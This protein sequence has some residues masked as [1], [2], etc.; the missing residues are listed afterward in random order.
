MS[1]PPHNSPTDATAIQRRYCKA[2]PC[3]TSPPGEG[4]NTRV[5]ATM[6]RISCSSKPTC[7]SWRA[8]STIF[9]R[10]SSWISPRNEPPCV[11]LSKSSKAANIP[12]KWAVTTLEPAGPLPGSGASAFASICTST[13]LRG[14]S[15]PS[16]AGRLGHST[17]SAKKNAAAQSGTKV[18]QWLSSQP[19]GPAG[20]AVSLRVAVRTTSGGESRSFAAVSAPTPSSISAKAMSNFSA[21]PKPRAAPP[22]CLD[23]SGA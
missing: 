7:H 1:R 20:R 10:K 12:P 6:R 22:Q 15:P 17:K 14:A 18:T 3:V 21:A 11:V 4:G 2:P 5:A 13:K 8:T 23:I 9:G 19:S 16:S